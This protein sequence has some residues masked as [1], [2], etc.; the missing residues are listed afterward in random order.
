[1]ARG[2]SDAQLLTALHMRD[3]LGL[4]YDEIARRVGRLAGMTCTKNMM[5]G[6]LRRIDRDTAATDCGNGNGSMPA[7]WWVR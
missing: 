4:T 3:R 7:D 5:I 2:L 6:A 1:M